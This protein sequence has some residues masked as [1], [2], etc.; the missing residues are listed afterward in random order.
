MISFLCEQAGCSRNTNVRLGTTSFEDK[1]QFV[2]WSNALDNL[3]Q[4]EQNVR[5]GRTRAVYEQLDRSALGLPK[6][7]A[8]ETDTNSSDVRSSA[9][10][11]AHG[12][13]ARLVW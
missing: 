7:N 2:A 11:T 1:E 12:V 4:F 8:N 6:Q 3:D 9:R 13:S 5:D 10:F